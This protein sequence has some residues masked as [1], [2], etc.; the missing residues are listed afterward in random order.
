MFLPSVAKPVVDPER[1]PF[2]ARDVRFA[3]EAVTLPAH[4]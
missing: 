2:E 1:E 3:R 4:S